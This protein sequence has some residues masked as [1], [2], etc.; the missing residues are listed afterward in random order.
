MTVLPDSSKILVWQL[1]VSPNAF[2]RTHG[3]YVR[4]SV[5]VLIVCLVIRHA[6]GLDNSSRG[7]KGNIAHT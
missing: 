2:G 7:S 4:M 3:R 1:E 5:K 6:A